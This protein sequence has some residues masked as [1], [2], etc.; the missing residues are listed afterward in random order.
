MLLCGVVSKRH[1]G[2]PSI[3]MLP[4][5]TLE[6]RKYTRGRAWT[7]FVITCWPCHCP[8]AA[9]AEADKAACSLAPFIPFQVRG[10]AGMH[11]VTIDVHDPLL[12]CGRRFAVL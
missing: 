1:W 4:H 6:H 10:L 5:I 2:K 3:E 9:H 8:V 7:L 11:Q 12:M